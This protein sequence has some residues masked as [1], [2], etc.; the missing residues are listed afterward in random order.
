MAR[1]YLIEVRKLQ[2]QGPYLLGGFSG[3][4]L[5]AYEMAQQLEAVGEKV[6]TL[7]MLDTPLAKPPMAN[8]FERMIIRGMKLRRGGLRFIAEW[9]KK[10][11][12]WELEK[13][14]R[15]QEIEQYKQAPTDFRSELI[16]DGF[17]EALNTYEIRPY[18]GRVTIFRPPPDRD[19]VLPGGRLADK[20]GEIQEKHNHWDPYTPGGIDCYEVPGDHDSMVLEPHV[21]VLGAKVCQVLQKAQDKLMRQG[22]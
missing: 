13:R 9:P 3:G 20:Y 12:A 18:S 17:V 10:R 15:K 16:R 7:I 21:R 4:G 22:E 8:A 19:Y 14:R 6:E 2:P 11:I 1:D 5:T